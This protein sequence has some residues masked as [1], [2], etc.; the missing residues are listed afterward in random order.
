MHNTSGCMSAIHC[1]TRSRRA[2]SELTFQVAIRTA[3][4][5]ANCQRTSYADLARRRV[6]LTGSGTGGASITATAAFEARFLAGGDGGSVCNHGRHG[7]DRRGCGYRWCLLRPRLG[8]LRRLN[9]RLRGR[10]LHRPLLRHRVGDRRARPAP[11]AGVLGA[12]AA[13]AAA[14]RLRFG[15][16]SAGVSA[17]GT[18]HRRHRR[19]CQIDAAAGR[20][21]ALDDEGDR[22]ADLHELAGAAR[23]RV[24]H[25]AQRHVSLDVADPH[26]CAV[27]RVV[28]DDRV[29]AAARLVMFDEC[30]EGQA[31]RWCRCSSGSVQRRPSPA[32]ASACQQPWPRRA[33]SLPRRCLA[34]CRRPRPRLLQRGTGRWR[35]GDGHRLARLGACRFGLRRLAALGLT[36][37]LATGRAAYRQA[38]DED[39]TDVWDRLSADQAA[40]VEEPA[41][42]SVELLVAVVRQ[43]RCLHLVGDAQH[44]RVA[45]ADGAGRW[46]NDL[47]VADSSVELGDLLGVDAMAERGV[48]H[49]RDQRVGMLR[50]CTPQRPR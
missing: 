21:E 22:F 38:V 45:A 47:V 36:D 11:T 6:A 43:D 19:D 5:V 33:D 46:S 42:S 10:L 29:D 37:R 44:E 13:V 12:G 20:G 3:A 9:R 1:S 15:V 14:F 26:V 4:T 27:R 28:L 25:Q 35:R 32:R 24:G 39:P 40:F 48:D 2:F 41:V 30:E 49:D 50:L 31:G 23:R 7:R 8:R 16:A 34:C 17:G 18:L